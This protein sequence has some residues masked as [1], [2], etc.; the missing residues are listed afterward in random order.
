MSRGLRRERSENGPVASKKPTEFDDEIS[1][2]KMWAAA[3]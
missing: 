1:I 2:L 3:P